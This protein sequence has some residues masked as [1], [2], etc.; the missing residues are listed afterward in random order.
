M[1][2]AGFETAIPASERPLT[3]VLDREIKR[4]GHDKNITRRIK[5]QTKDKTKRERERSNTG[6]KNNEINVR[7]RE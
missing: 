7:S 2:P 4:T 1:S 5:E 3:G 6:R